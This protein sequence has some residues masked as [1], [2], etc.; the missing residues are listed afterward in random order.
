MTD[1]IEK[2]QIMTGEPASKG[3]II[4]R[5]NMTTNDRLFVNGRVSD[6]QIK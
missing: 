2:D 5:R 1:L 4:F 6:V 3:H